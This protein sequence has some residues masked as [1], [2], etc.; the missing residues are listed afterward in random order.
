MF[1]FWGQ[2]QAFALEG[3]DAGA[4]SFDTLAPIFPLT[5]KSRDSFAALM[6]YVPSVDPDAAYF[7]SRV[8]RAARIPA[9]APTQAHPKLS[10]LPQVATLTGCYRTLGEHADDH[11]K[12]SRYGAPPQGGVYVSR[13]IGYHDIVVSWSGPGMIPNAALI[14]AAHRN[15][16]LCLGTIFQ[17]DKRIFDSSAVPAKQVAAKFVEL[18]LYFGFDGYFMNFELGTPE[19]HAQILDLLAMMREEAH[20]QGK[21]DFYIQFYDGSADMDQLMPIETP[22]TPYVP[23]ASFADSTMLDQGWSGYSMTHGCCSG[24]PTDAASVYAYC[25]K[26]GL[27]PY[28]S[29]Y[30]GY[31]LYPGP[32]YLGLS[33]PSVIH[34][35]DSAT[36][37]GSLQVYSFEDGLHTMQLALDKGKGDAAPALSREE[38]FYALERRFF[39]GQ[40]QNPA[41]DNAPNAEQAHIYAEVA[42]RTRRYTDYSPTEDHPTDQVKLPITYGVANFTVEHSV[43]GAFPFLTHFNLGAGDAFFVDGAKQGDRPWFNLGIQD[44]LPTWQWW[45]EPM[46]GSLDR[47]AAK[48]APLR[49]EYDRAL[50]FDGGASLHISGSLRAR[51]GVSLRLYKTKLPVQNAGDLSLHL[52]W[53]GLA[54]TKE[55]LLAGLIFEDAP[56]Q[57]EW[58]RFTQ[59]DAILHEQLDHGWTRSRMTLAPYRGRTLAALLIGFHH[60]KP[61]HADT[62]VDVHIGE[63]YAGL[64]LKGET[65]SAPSSFT[66]EA[67][68]AGAAQGTMQVRLR[69]Q[70]RD[71][72]AYYDLYAMNAT[73]NART[74]LGR[75]TADCYYVE[76]VQAEQ[77]SAIAF[78]LVATSRENPL[79]RSLPA[80]TTVQAA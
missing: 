5:A 21:S 16:A 80:R 24:R 29:A 15:G 44:L 36:A 67:H 49:V 59:T 19:G 56:D 77:G 74:W 58:V 75:V 62:P 66:V 6:D 11:Y 78:E 40:S 48:Y 39:S 46:Q 65:H 43:I 61:A 71:E 52:V 23:A 32:G 1:S 73:S 57:A 30:F 4:N 42:G 17:P 41:L 3:Q 20:R 9:F 60:E 26:N 34:P 51:D 37:Y 7:R 13:M 28:R 2:K 53:Q 45:L 55:Y 31:Q 27:D 63:I 79:L 10:S 72:D 50:A 35:N 69:W 54:E 38:E 47:S 70:M 64:P 8:P 68:A 33:A 25:R 12:R 76:S 18:A 14:D 22:G